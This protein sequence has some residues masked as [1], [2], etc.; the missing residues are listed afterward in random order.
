[1]F[2]LGFHALIPLV[3]TDAEKQWLYIPQCARCLGLC[4]QKLY[5]MERME[6]KS[7]CHRLWILSLSQELA[8]FF[9]RYERLLVCSQSFANTPGEMVDWQKKVKKIKMFKEQYKVTI[10]MSFENLSFK[11]LNSFILP[12]FTQ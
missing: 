2:E 12:E 8:L 7:T 3:P 1:M 10:Y 6:R 9:H 5:Y 4:K 11:T